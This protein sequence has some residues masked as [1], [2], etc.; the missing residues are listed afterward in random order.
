[1]TFDSLFP[2]FLEDPPKHDASPSLPFKFSGGFGYDTATVGFILSVQGAYSML[3]TVALFPWVAKR[4]GALRLF[5]LIAASYFLLYFLTPYTVLLPDHLRMAGIYMLLVWK[6]TLSTLAYPANAIL[7]ANSALSTLTLGTING[8][9]A[10]TASLCR[11]F[12]PIVSGFLFALGGRAGYAGLVWWV[13]GLISL[14]GAVV[15]FQMAEAPGRLDEKAQEEGAGP[16]AVA[17]SELPLR[18]S[19][20]DEGS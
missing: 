18:G 1:M 7:L 19:P 2:V 10:S 6:C 16:V 4:L 12:G 20:R 11:A 14:A 15:S 8:V 17:P 3:S 13:S 9:A 5:R